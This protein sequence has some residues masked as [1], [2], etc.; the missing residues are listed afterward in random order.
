[1]Q[2][3]VDMWDIYQIC[4]CHDTQHLI[5]FIDN[6]QVTKAKRTKHSVRALYSKE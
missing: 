3:K 6:A 2:Q 5:I 4:P 1:M